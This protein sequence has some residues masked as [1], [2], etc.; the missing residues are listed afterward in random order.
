MIDRIL[1]ENA[2]VDA[3]DAAARESGLYGLQRLIFCAAAAKG[4]IDA[5]NAI[6]D[7]APAGAPVLPV[8]PKRKPRG[9]NKP[10]A[11]PAVA[12][13][14]PPAPVPPAPVP[15]APAAALPFGS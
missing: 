11:A 9:P 6:P 14:V 10:K 2:V 4:V 8:A 13:P 5:I 15:P 1:L 7:T 3:V 12:A